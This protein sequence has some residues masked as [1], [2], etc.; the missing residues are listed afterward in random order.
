MKEDT[1]KFVSETASGVLLRRSRIGITGSGDTF[2]S[3]RINARNATP[4]K[5]REP[6]TRV[7]VHNKSSVA[8]RLK[9]AS[10]GATNATKVN[11][12]SQSILF[13][14][15]MGAWGAWEGTM[16]TWMNTSIEEAIRKGIWM[17]NAVL[18]PKLSEM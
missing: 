3:T 2:A 14:F 10:K 5:A 18:H 1:D 11:D 17:R 7:S 15:S 12:P 16:L 8:L 4:L 13:S 9:P 6:Q